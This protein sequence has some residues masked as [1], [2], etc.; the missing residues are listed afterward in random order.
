MIYS[1]YPCVYLLVWVPIHDRTLNVT[2]TSHFVS[3]L[4]CVTFATRDI[5]DFDL[6]KNALGNVQFALL[7]MYY[8]VDTSSF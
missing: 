5:N 8:W 4:F 2:Q 6:L 7:M 3:C 1:K